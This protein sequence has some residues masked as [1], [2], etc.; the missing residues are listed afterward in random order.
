MQRTIKKS[1]MTSIK[2]LGLTNTKTTKDNLSNWTKIAIIFI[3]ITEEGNIS[4]HIQVRQG[5]ESN[6]N[7]RMVF[8]MRKFPVVQIG[9]GKGEFAVRRCFGTKEI[10]P[11]FGWKIRLSSLMQPGSKS[12]LNSR[13]TAFFLSRRINNRQFFFYLSESRQRLFT[14][15]YFFFLIIRVNRYGYFFGTKV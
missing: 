5:G 9:V 2:D 1:T 12:S 3:N 15:P 14:N 11:S 10:F 8:D 4:S 6:G 13:L 7:L